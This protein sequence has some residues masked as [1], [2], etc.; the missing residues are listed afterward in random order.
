MLQLWH[1][2]LFIHMLLL[3]RSARYCLAYP[4]SPATRRESPTSHHDARMNHRALSNYQVLAS[5]WQIPDPV[6]II[7]L[8]P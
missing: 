2:E 6:S 1:S 8:R 5:R 3:R 7:V 4:A